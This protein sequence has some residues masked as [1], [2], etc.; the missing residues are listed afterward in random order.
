MPPGKIK[1][2]KSKLVDILEHQVHQADQML[3]R[4]TSDTSAASVETSWTSWQNTVQKILQ[5][6]FSDESQ[7]RLFL[8]A[9]ATAETQQ[10]RKDRKQELIRRF[11]KSIEFLRSLTSDIVNG[12]HDP[13]EADAIDQSTAIYIL[14]RILNNFHLHVRAMYQDSVHGR[15]G[16]KMEDLE[17]IQIGNEYDVQRIL[18]ALIRPVFPETRM[19]VTED[20]GYKSVRY[21]LF[22]DDYRVAVEVKCTRANMSVK[23]LT[24]ELGSDAFHYATDHLFLFIYDKAKVIVNVDAFKKTYRRD[25]DSFGK[26]METFVIQPVII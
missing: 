9:A 13:V 19:E 11:I 10:V 1:G 24:E 16:I 23:D 3:A 18:F 14:R 5:S 2:E 26:N 12:L 21:D 22:L 20:S 8:L 25:K 4:I 7:A 17:R 6:H 15:A